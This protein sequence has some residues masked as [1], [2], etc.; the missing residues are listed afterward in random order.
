MLKHTHSEGNSVPITSWGSL[1]DHLHLLLFYTH[2]TTF[3]PVERVELLVT[4]KK[5]R[6]WPANNEININRIYPKEK[7]SSGLADKFYNRDNAFTLT[8]LLK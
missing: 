2:F 8:A 1:H 5:L 7:L 4:Y 3:E 6:L